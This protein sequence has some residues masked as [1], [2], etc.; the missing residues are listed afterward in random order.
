M[1]KPSYIMLSALSK[2]TN[3]VTVQ[4][5][6]DFPD[7]QLFR[8]QVA[9]VKPSLM[10]NYLHYNNGARYILKDTD[11]D[12]QLLKLNAQRE[13]DMKK[14]AAE[15]LQDEQLLMKSNTKTQQKSVTEEKNTK[16]N[17]EKQSYKSVLDQDYSIEN[18]KIP[19]LDL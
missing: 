13:A 9:E 16:R 17:E 12:S 1:F 19:G 4:V 10:R 6:K 15:A 5:L 3:K 18:V 7:F 14:L 2:R 8:G 11:I